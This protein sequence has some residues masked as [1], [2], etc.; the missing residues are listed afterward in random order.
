MVRNVSSNDEDLRTHLDDR[1][2][3]PPGHGTVSAREV[4]VR[5][6]DDPGDHLQPW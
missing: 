3:Q 1:V 2:V 6:M 5:Y 4:E